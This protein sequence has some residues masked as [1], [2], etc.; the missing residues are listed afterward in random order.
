MFRSLNLWANIMLGMAL[1]I[2]LAVGGLTWGSLHHLYTV[3]SNAER[4]ELQQLAE[5]IRIEI[6]AKT[7]TAE[8][9]ARF[10][11]ATPEIQGRFAARDRDWLRH[12]L[13][14]AYEALAQ[15]GI[16][17][18]QFHL[19]PAQSFLRLHD[20]ER[21]GDDLAGGRQLVVDA[22]A[23]QRSERGLERGATGLSARGVV[24]VFHQGSH[25]G[26]V[27]FGIALGHSFF[28]AFQRGRGADG[29]FLTAGGD[30]GFTTLAGRPARGPLLGDAA[31]EA[32]MG[33]EPQ[34]Q[35]IV[36]DGQPT[37][38]QVTPVRDYAGEVI[39]L[40]EVAKDRSR[41]LE[42]LADART[43]AW[44]V[45]VLAALL[46]LLIAQLTA[47]ALGRRIGAVAH[48]IDQ[49]AA[50][51]LSH[52]IPSSGRDELAAL[53]RA[54]DT[55]RRSLSALVAEVERNAT[56]VYDAS[57][58]ISAAVDKQAAHSSDM[59][60]SMSEITSTMEELSA[61]SSQIAE[62]SESV[63]AV[64]QR[65]LDDSRGGSEAMQRL[66]E[67]MRVIKRD[68]ETALAEIVELGDR[69]K[70][71]SRVMDIINS[72]ADQTRL[73][74]FNAALEASS[75]G[76]AGKRFGVIAA[77][78][79]RLADSVTESTGEIEDK[80]GQIQAAI[81]RLVVSSEKGS[82]GIDEGMEESS[83]TAQRLQTMVDGAGETTNAAQQINLSS[84]QQKTASGQVVEVLRD[85][86]TTTAET[87]DS[88]RHIS[89]IAQEMT[90]LSG[91]L[92]ERVDRFLLDRDDA[93]TL[94]DA[95]R[96]TETE[97]ERG[98]AALPA[99]RAEPD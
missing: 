56:H 86:V 43:H 35:R 34:L 47:R 16:A 39:G 2:G 62:Y 9:L 12:T 58:D 41:H 14:P 99:E 74:A 3:I 60:S 46:G 71:I 6:E 4:A 30:D 91:A 94:T 49:V 28:D 96:E 72:V 19:P 84:Q 93:R 67:R 76:D 40:L 26:S 59:S 29:A 37:T 48:G 21:F 85:M 50:G 25:V 95:E 31:L 8:A 44:L 66:V 5:N 89:G 79:R 18:V 52:V 10:V 87:A 77:E 65:T 11:A 1:A 90:G 53:A 15:D 33:G 22:N 63:V 70:E 23:R 55:M 78:I 64:A 69:S 68:N 45:G 24:P 88:V 51:D 32:A 81:S 83:Q 73:I 82:K 17:Q 7:R 75:A 54:A 38:V 13:T 61:S 92:K 36:L 20:P 42:V 57:K 97:T 27:E 80:V 98:R